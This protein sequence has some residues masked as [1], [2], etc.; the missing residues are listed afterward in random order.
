MWQLGAQRVFA[1]AAEARRDA[2]G[3]DLAP[4]GLLHGRHVRAVARDRYGICALRSVEPGEL[5]YNYRWTS[6]DRC[7][8]GAATCVG[9]M[10]S[11]KKNRLGAAAR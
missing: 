4:D 7:C 11:V 3:V 8:C 9:V 1:D 2:D 6:F 5:T 10:N